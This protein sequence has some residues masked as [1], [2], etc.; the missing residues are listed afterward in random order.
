MTQAAYRGGD[1]SLDLGPEESIHAKRATVVGRIVLPLL[2]SGPALVLGGRAFLND[3]PVFD[4]NAPLIVN[5]AWVVILV[6]LPL[7]SAVS[8]VNVLRHRDDVVVLHERGLRAR[9]SGV[10]TR[11]PFAD[12]VGVKSRVVRTRGGV[13]HDHEVR[14][15]G[16][17]LSLNADYDRID[18]LM[19]AIRERTLEPIAERTREELEAGRTVSFG[20]VSLER[21]A[22]VVR[23]TRLPLAALDRIELRSGVV[24]VYAKRR[25]DAWAEQDVS[26]ILNAHVLIALLGSRLRQLVAAANE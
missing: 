17:V 9:V 14:F 10:G 13:V 5:A 21:E 25:P 22:L 6:I 26:E 3:V 2:M 8:I 7:A 11:V 1:S 16:G 4:P 23:G 15:A 20:P 19:E 12:V 24:Y 18:A